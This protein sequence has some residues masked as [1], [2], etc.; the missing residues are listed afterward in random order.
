M[1]PVITPYWERAE[2]P[3][4]LVAPLK[5]LNIGGATIKGYGSAVRTSRHGGRGR[6]ENGVWGGQVGAVCGKEAA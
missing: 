1:A 5:A 2:F 6:E 3:Y 4:E